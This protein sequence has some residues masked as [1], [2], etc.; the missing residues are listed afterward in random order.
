MTGQQGAASNTQ[1]AGLDWM[2]ALDFSL[3][4]S[5]FRALYNYLK[6]GCNEIEVGLFYHASNVRTRGKGFKIKQ[7][8]FRLDIRK[9]AFNS[10]VVRQWKRLPREVLEPP[11]LEVFQRHLDLALAD[12]DLVV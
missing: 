4:R 2:A 10:H 6:G 11:S 12:T 9:N 7:W 1:K 3:E 5:T 8:K